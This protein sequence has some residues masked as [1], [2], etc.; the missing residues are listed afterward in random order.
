VDELTVAYYEISFRIRFLQAK[1]EVFQ[2]LF[3]TVME[4]RYPGDFVRVRPW[5]KIG[6][7]KND[8]YLP[9]K[10]QLFQC[11]APREM[12]L[13]ACKAKV[14][15]DFRGALPYW[16]DHFDQWFFAHNDPEGLAPDILKQLLDLSATHAPVVL[17]QWGYPDLFQEF[18]QLSQ[19]NLLTLLGPAPGRKDVIDLRL[20]DVKRLLEHIALQPEPM[21]VDVRQVPAD[22][23]EYN[24]LSQATGTLLKAGMTRSEIVKKYLRGI[25]DQTR[26]DRTAAAFRLR[27][28]ELKGQ[29]VTPDDIFTG[30]QMF[31]SGE[32]VATPTQQ[33]ATLA[34]LAFF[35]E[36][37]EIFERPPEL[38]GGDS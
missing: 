3:S 20:E 23:L 11:Y 30:L 14:E 31:V 13:A 33:A 28:A 25:A 18:K 8:G 12:T 29:G 9:S 26:Y 4:M 21:T 15:E 27:Y 32:S 17:S 2:D 37:C 6:D 10:R 5:G 19:A 16:K 1:G 35:F 22:K 34:I 36:V 7:R 38:A 24:Q